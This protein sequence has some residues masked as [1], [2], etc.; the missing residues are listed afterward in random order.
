LEQLASRRT[1]ELFRH[2]RDRPFVLVEPGGNPGDSLIYRGAEKLARAAGLSYQALD[3]AEFMQSGC[4]PAAVVYLHGSGGYNTWCSG[5]PMLELEKAVTTHPGVV[6]QGPATFHDDPAFLEQRIAAPLRHRKATRLFVLARERVS[7]D[8]V[9]RVLPGWT[10]P[11]IDHDTA[12]N[13]D[14]ADLAA[15]VRPGNHTLY[16]IR[17]D[18]EARPFR[19]REF[20]GVWGDPRKLARSLDPWIRLHAEAAEIVT[21][22]L[23]SSIVGS[24]L[25]RPTTLLPNSYFKNRA[26]WEYSLCQ[27]GVRWAEEVPVGALG[28]LLSEIAPARRL[29]GARPIQRLVR[30]CHGIG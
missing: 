3:H 29:L 14:A 24:I 21:N 1:F 6:I 20:F 25:G 4:D 5:K 27:R 7:Y 30:T 16:A 11:M 10:E 8:A 17:Q 13:L 28:R 12:L 26:V 2:F 15:D 22:R 19:H 23:H 9:R 18:M